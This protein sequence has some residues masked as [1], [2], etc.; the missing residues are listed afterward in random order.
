M[1]FALLLRM[2]E[3]QSRARQ[4]LLRSAQLEVQL[5][6]RSIQPHFLMNALTSILEWVEVEPKRAARF[7][8]ALA[9]EFRLLSKISAEKLI[10]LE[11]E[12]QLFRTHLSVMS[13]QR[14]ISF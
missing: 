12:V 13:L 11:L 9:D 1:L 10:P 14:E 6:K 7:I 2:R 8:E 4:T 5:L 3:E